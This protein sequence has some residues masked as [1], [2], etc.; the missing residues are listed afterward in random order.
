VS[1]QRR[2]G[3]GNQPKSEKEDL[4]TQVGERLVSAAC[5]GGKLIK[6]RSTQKPEKQV[7]D[8]GTYLIGNP[9]G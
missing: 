9:P 1:G 3:T 8:Q 7:L 5:G 6:S 2:G 4:G